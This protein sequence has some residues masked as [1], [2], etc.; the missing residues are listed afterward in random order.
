[1]LDDDGNERAGI[2]LVQGQI[3][4]R[5][6]SSDPT[7]HCEVLA[8]AGEQGEGTVIGIELW[9]NGNSVGGCSAVRSGSDIE[10]HRFP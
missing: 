4:L 6:S 3:E 5:L 8:F 9:I 1:V 10:V 2:E 7:N